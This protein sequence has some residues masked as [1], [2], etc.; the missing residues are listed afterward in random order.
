MI[1]QIHPNTKKFDVLDNVVTVN[2]ENF[3][4]QT[5]PREK[6]SI[7]ILTVPNPGGQKNQKNVAITINTK[8]IQNI[9]SKV[10]S[11]V[12]ISEITT[13]R[14]LEKLAKREPDLVF[15]GVKYFEFNGAHI[16]LNDFLELHNIC[17]IGSNHAALD[18]EH[19]KGLAKSIVKEAGVVTADYVVMKANSF[20]TRKA[21]NMVYPV[22]VKPV[23]GGDSIGIDD[24]S[25]VFNPE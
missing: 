22:F 10:Y 6:Q 14:C 7:E 4:N 17:Y 18:C 13:P 15:S 11:K 9:L 25:V 21:A 24:L 20:P 23:T 2:F 3:Q 12:C 1:K 8:L 5:K 19:D 16:W